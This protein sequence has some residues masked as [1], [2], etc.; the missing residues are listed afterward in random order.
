MFPL[1]WE[2]PDV[3][4]TSDS[5]PDKSKFESHNVPN[6]RLGIKEDEDRELPG[7]FEI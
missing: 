7:A 3:P 1:P 2:V 4:S 5:R 6:A